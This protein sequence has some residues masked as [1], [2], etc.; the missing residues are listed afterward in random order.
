MEQM[1]KQVETRNTKQ[2]SYI[3]YRIVGTIFG[4]IEIALAFRLIFKLLGA[5]PANIFVQGLYTVT[6]FF[7][8]IFEGIF[9]QA[10][11]NGAVTTAIFEPATLIAMLVIA[12]IA[13]I[14]LKLIKPRI[15]NST[16]RTEYTRN[17][18]QVK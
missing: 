11:T 10:T 16:A 5:N 18:N 14:F 15:G 9:Y 8:G 4:I 7:V 17:E 1:E 6:H 2:G 3:A 12:V 13:W